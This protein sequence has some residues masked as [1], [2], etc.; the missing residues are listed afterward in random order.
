MN[1]FSLIGSQDK[2]DKDRIEILNKV[3]CIH[4]PEEDPKESVVSR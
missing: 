3:L 1:S 4:D 2:H